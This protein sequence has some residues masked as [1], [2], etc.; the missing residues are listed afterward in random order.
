MVT[1][2]LE[3]ATLPR[4]SYLNTEYGLKSWLLTL[5]H[6]RIAL[7]YLFTTIFF[8]AIGGMAASLIRLEL[9][10]PVG[11]LVSSILITSSSPFTASLWCSSSWCP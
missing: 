3:P 10:T 9:L 4:E 8:F 5:D 7:L 11:D 2:S 6:K 1:T